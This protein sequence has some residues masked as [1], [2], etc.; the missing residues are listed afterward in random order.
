VVDDIG[1]TDDL[2]FRF[3]TERL[4]LAL[5]ATVGERWNRRIER[6]RTPG[7]LRRWFVESGLMERPMQVRPIDL[8]STR[9]LREAIYAVAKSVI[10][11]SEA[12]AQD[13]R[14][15][16][17]FAAVAPLAP[18]LTAA[19]V[20]WVPGSRSVP[21]ALSWL[22]RDAIELLGSTDRSRLREC[23]SDTCGLLFT[24]TSR[25][26]SRRW[27]S[28]DRCGGAARAAQYRRRRAP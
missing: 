18:E 8:E 26:Q 21:A 16:N 20:R 4:S 9:Q 5:T 24:D 15:I 12:R 13:R 17:A 2:A 25:P 23:A 28:S 6:L 27:C 19:G 1:T 14:M 7:D 11:G 10:D 22:A 3:V